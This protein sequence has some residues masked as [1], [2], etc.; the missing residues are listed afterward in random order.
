MSDIFSSDNPLW[1]TIN[2]MWQ[3]QLPEPGQSFWKRIPKPVWLIKDGEKI[4]CESK[5]GAAKLIGASTGN[6]AQ[7]INRN[8]KC[9]GYRVYDV[10]D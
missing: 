10:S 9:R 5:T 2:G 3:R 7:A 1:L 8:C 6:I 4:Y